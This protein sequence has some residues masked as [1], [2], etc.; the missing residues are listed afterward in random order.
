MKEITII[1]Y[2][3]DDGTEFDNL[4]ECKRYEN[5]GCD[6]FEL[7]KKVPHCFSC[8]DEIFPSGCGDDYTLYF[9]CLNKEQA[10]IVL[11]WAEV[12]NVDVEVSESQMVGN[13]IVLPDVFGCRGTID[14]IDK[15]YI[16]GS[17]ITLSEW[18]GHIAMIVGF[19]RD[20]EWETE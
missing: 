14:G 5:E 13:V 17:L 8:H 20:D 11:K 19:V 3:A 10:R 1:K 15:N 18:I 4:E 6:Y 2:K 12:N 9:K 7:I 16:C